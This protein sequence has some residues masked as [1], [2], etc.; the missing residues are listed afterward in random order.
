MTLDRI[1]TGHPLFEGVF[2]TGN[3]AFRSPRI[4]RS[5]EIVGKGFLNILRMADGRPFFVEKRL[6]EGR[7]LI[8]GTGLKPS[9]SDLPFSSIFAP[10]VYRSAVYLATPGSVEEAPNIVGRP[11]FL[12]AAVDD[13]QS[14]YSVTT[15]SG[16]RIIVS[17]SV[18]AERMT[19][20]IPDPDESG[21]YRFEQNG[22]LKG[23]R[24]VNI[25]PRESDL[26]STENFD[27]RGLFPDGRVYFLE[28]AAS[29][30]EVIPR[31]RRGR[32]LWREMILIALLILI[33]ETVV[34]RETRSVWNDTES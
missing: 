34:A 33:L 17:P 10:L 20:S 23:S 12:T 19:L 4:R 22:H 11:L 6:G 30:E 2:E 32:E 16:E 15:P 28:G 3:A 27:L 31:S 26:H 25:D 29:L 14:E 21:V 1:D 9:W 18:A 24:A 13:I 7:V 5:V 8:L